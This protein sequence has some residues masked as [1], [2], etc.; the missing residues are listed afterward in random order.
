M[1]GKR[2]KIKVP[3]TTADKALEV[4]GG[5]ALL[6]L[7]ALVIYFYPKLPDIVPIHFNFNGE[8]DGFGDRQTMFLLPVI[9]TLLFM[10]LTALSLYPHTFNYP[11]KITED[12]ALRQYTIAVRMMRFLK[13]GVIILFGIIEYGT[14]RTA[15]QQAQ[16]LGRGFIFLVFALVLIPVFYSL[17]QSAS[18]KNKSVS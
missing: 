18:Q 5:I 16:G 10:V 9:G 12:N 6:L 8:A 7:W 2:P 11:V 4:S 14:I 15:T 3:F 1:D 17:V 13:L